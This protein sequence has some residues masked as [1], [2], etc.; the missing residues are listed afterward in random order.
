MIFLGLLGTAY[1]VL[2]PQA[3]CVD[4]K[5]NQNEQGVDCGGVCKRV[6][7]SDARGVSIL[8]A[9]PVFVDRGVYSVVAN[10]SNPNVTLSA[11]DVG[12]RFK[13]YDERNLLIY[14][15]TGSTDVPANANFTVF[16]GGVTTGNRLPT[17]VF[18]EFTETPSW[19]KA[20]R[21]VSL[22]VRDVEFF[23]DPLPRLSARVLNQSLEE[24]ENV[25]VIALL[26]DGKDNVIGAS[27]TFIDRLSRESDRV[28]VFT[29][30]NS[31]S[32]A[33]SRI[34]VDPLPPARFE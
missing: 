8:W 4:Q 1:F 29:W 30:P 33:P 31:F 20:R 13:L 17:R 21:E 11:R 3:T 24:V 9:R 14:E 19:F 28:V 10:L 23:A 34:E 2:V 5:Q 26:F 25:K 16:E 32:T 22:K 6:C 15:R 12:Y 18:F 7:A 27:E